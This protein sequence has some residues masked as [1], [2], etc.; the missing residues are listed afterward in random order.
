M[1]YLNFTILILFL[2][3]FSTRVFAGDL[4]EYQFSSN[5][6][7]IQPIPDHELVVDG[8]NS[9]IDLSNHFRCDDGYTISYEVLNPNSEKLSVS[10]YNTLLVM[11][12]LISESF[13]L[14]ITIKATAGNIEV[15]DTFM[16][17]VIKNSANITLTKELPDMQMLKDGGT[18][19]ENLYFYFTCNSP[20]SLSYSAVSSDISLVE[21]SVLGNTLTVTTVEG[22]TGSTT[23]TVT[24]MAAGES[25]DATFNVD[26]IDASTNLEIVEE[27]PDQA[28]SM[29]ADDIVIDLTPYFTCDAQFNLTYS[30]FSNNYGLAWAFV[31]DNNLVLSISEDAVGTSLVQVYAFAATDII[32]QD[33]ILQVGDGEIILTQIQDLPDQNIRLGDNSVEVD[34][35]EYFK[36]KDGYSMSFDA[37]SDDEYIIEAY[38]EGNLM[39]FN[40]EDCVTGTTTVV[41]DVY[42]GTSSIQAFF[43]VTVEEATSLIEDRVSSLLS[44]YPN[45]ARDYAEVITEEKGTLSIYNSQ[46]ELLKTIN[47]SSNLSKINLSDFQKGLYI[48]QLRD[49][50]TVSTSKLMVQ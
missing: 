29:N 32:S 15:E 38:V 22:Q 23:V 49:S 21:A 19:E 1:K 41:V 30:A 24:A 35:T 11:Q 2:I 42:A 45:P 20:Y 43:E 28:I 26:V 37:F 50:S 44:V 12:P 36:C 14:E 10:I 39:K 46:G 17:N 33:F 5:L 4:N 31:E 47:V 7:L 40:T 3:S 13:S 18:L 8:I 48:L 6:E 25:F 34:L 27:I 9:A 16:V